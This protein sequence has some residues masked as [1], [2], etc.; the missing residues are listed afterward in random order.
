MTVSQQDT[1]DFT[2]MY[3]THDAFRRDLERL[4]A[5]AAAGKAGTPEVRAGWESFKSQLI[6]HHTV[7]D[8]YLWPRLRSAVAGRPDDLALLDDMEAEHARIDPL[9]AA[10]E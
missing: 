6:V 2:V 1:I 8:A 9:L 10:V 3:A 5:A 7:E 4:E